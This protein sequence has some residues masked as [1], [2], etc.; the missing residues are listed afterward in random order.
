MA[1]QRGILIGALA[2]AL[3]T[4]CAAPPASLTPTL[5][6]EFFTAELPAEPLPTGTSAPTPL[7]VW[8]GTA[9]PARLRELAQAWNLPAAADQSTAAVQLNI[10]QPALGQLNVSNWIYALV[11]PFPTIVDGVTSS[12]LRNCWSGSPSGPFGGLPLLMEESTLAALTLLWGPPA[13]GAA[14]AMP[15]DQLLDAAWGDAPS[16][17]IVPFE[18]LEARWKVL[19][20]DGQSPIRKDFEPERYPLVAGFRVYSAAPLEPELPESNRDPAKL[21]TVLLTGVT[22]LVRATAY[23]ME[24]KGVLYP[25]RD[26]RDWMLDAD[27]AHVSNEIPFYSACGPPNP[28]QTKLVFCS[29]P[30]YM[31]LL[32]DIG[33]DVIELTGNHFG[34]YG[35]D[36]ML[37]TLAMYN[38]LGI[39]YYG[40]GAD[41]ADAQNALLLEHNGNKIAFIGC[42]PPDTGKFPTATEDRPGAAPCDFDYMT[43]TI[44]DLRDHGYVVITTFQYY[45]YYSPEARPWQQEDFRLMSNAGAS[46]VSGSQAH[47]AQVLE[48]NGSA[49]IHYGLGNLFFDQMGEIPLIDGIRRE[50]LDRHIIY[51][52]RHVSTELLTAMLEDYS[53]PRPMT[54]EERADFLT[55]YFVESGWLTTPPLVEIEAEPTATLTPLSLPPL[56]GSAGGFYLETP[57]AGP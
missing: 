37:E 15:P 13:A 2:A 35:E 40:G 21:T 38:E 32:T 4:S 48:F 45:E 3:L 8:I 14:R 30:R 41:L 25:G 33:T 19:T 39:P 7:S 27:I 26:I 43:L 5:E 54:P 16:W 17:G 20:I 1:L 23:T 22:A 50:F 6:T 10:A 34:D 12:D 47:Y 57:T 9:V 28:S 51:D 56:V 18:M 29:S 53:R 11:A 36:A 31:D 52:G 55:E 49:F 24:V 44:Q 42:N 46:I